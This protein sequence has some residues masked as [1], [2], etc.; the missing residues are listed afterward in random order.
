MVE[1]NVLPNQKAEGPGDDENR[2]YEQQVGICL[3][4]HETVINQIK[5][6]S[7]KCTDRVKNAITQAFNTPTMGLEYNED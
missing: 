6:G 4:P 5:A 1:K 7:T 3:K 2:Q